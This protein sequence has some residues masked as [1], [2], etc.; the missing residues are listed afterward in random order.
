M[1]WLCASATHVRASIP[2][3]STDGAHSHV[4]PFRQE[5]LKPT[6]PPPFISLIPRNLLKAHSHCRGGPPIAATQSLAISAA[7]LLTEGCAVGSE[8]RWPIE[9]LSSSQTFGQLFLVAFFD[10]VRPM[11]AMAS[12]SLSMARRRTIV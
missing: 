2:T 3:P 6:L 4:D 5:V 11:W 10:P 7:A 1:H 8:P 12:K 9:F